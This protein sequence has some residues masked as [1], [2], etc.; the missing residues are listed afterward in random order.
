LGNLIENAVDFAVNT[1][2][3]D[4]TWTANEV[5]ITITDDG[6][7]FDAAVFERLG[8]PYVT[9]RGAAQPLPVKQADPR[10][11]HQGMGLGFFIAKT[12]TERTGGSIDFSNASRKG[13]QVTARWPRSALERSTS[14][15]G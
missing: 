7:G 5:K 10:G 12:L 2:T 4:A 9:T 6:P 1:V 13:A 14:S 8:E 3:I 15:K 11:D